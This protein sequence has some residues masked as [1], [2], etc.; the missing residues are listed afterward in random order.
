MT[1]FHKPEL[2]APT[3]DQPERR[4]D[5]D[6]V[7]IGA[8]LLLIFYHVGMFYVP[9]DWHI[10]SPHP[11]NWLQPLMVL[12]NPWRLTIL[13]IVSGA[14]TRF[15]ADKTSEWELASTRT[16]RLL[17]PLVFAMAVIVPPQIWLQ[18][19]QAN[20]DQLLPYSNFWLRYLTASGGWDW[21]GAPL[22]TPTWNHM[23]FVAY[24]LAYTLILAAS[25]FLAPE[26][27]RYL[28][29]KCEHALAGCGLL[30]WPT[31]YL[32]AVHLL[33]APHYPET[34]AFAGDWAVHASSWSA[35]LFGYLVAKS[36]TIW[37]S[38]ERWRW[39]ALLA[40]VTSYSAY[41]F[42]LTGWIVGTIAPGRAEGFIATIYG[43][44]QWAWV[45]AIL[46]LAKR[47]L[48]GYDTEI[49]RY[50]TEAIFPFY[51]MHQTIIIVTAYFLL[52]F[53]LP[54]AVESLII[55]GSTISGCVIT[56]ELVRHI[57]FLRPLFGLKRRVMKSDL[58]VKL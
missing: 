30:C 33:V 48:S 37:S 1:I 17:T 18:V 57:S 44:D 58:F 55:I 42:A 34:H 49:R 7:R 27:L 3:F 8:L 50:L 47:H 2:D 52:P 15:M 19:A 32:C 9:W 40:A 38:F 20:N 16:L 5:L 36:D 28:E 51:I 14:A 25:N 12:T 39:W 22:V 46:G 53:Q 26:L 31:V 54:P 35:F 24:L 41:A 23:W 56:F 6:W 21:H 10:K 4:L 13:F 11:Q 43:I 45:A 29:V